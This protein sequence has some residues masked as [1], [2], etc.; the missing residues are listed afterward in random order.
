MCLTYNTNTYSASTNMLKHIPC[1]FRSWYLSVVGVIS[2]IVSL[3]DI[4]SALRLSLRLTHNKIPYCVLCT[5]ES[6]FP[7][8][9]TA[10]SIRDNCGSAIGS[11][12]A[13]QNISTLFPLLQ[14]YVQLT[15]TLYDKKNALLYCRKS[16]SWLW[17]LPE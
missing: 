5:I 17:N 10:L 7:L 14:P 15:C 1:W 11:L 6:I 16:H 12:F 2:L 9:L 13:Q 8:G 3:S 4:Q